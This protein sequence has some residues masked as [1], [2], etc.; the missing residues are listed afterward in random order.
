MEFGILTEREFSHPIKQ[1]S[2]TSFCLVVFALRKRGKVL[3]LDLKLGL[4]LMTTCTFWILWSSDS[5][6]Q[7]CTE[8]T[9]TLGMKTIQISSNIN[10]INSNIIASVFL[11][12]DMYITLCFNFCVKEFNSDQHA[13]KQYLTFDAFWK[14]L[15]PGKMLRPLGTS[16]RNRS[17]VIALRSGIRYRW[18]C[19]CCCLRRFNSV[20]FWH[21]LA[22]LRDLLCDLFCM[23]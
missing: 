10:L 16:P 2:H 22:Y 12:C 17:S 13:T 15:C 9:W 11:L 21:C 5:R 8:F 1:T 23:E 20:W 6:L 14:I 19:C 18:F 4:A 7:K 3:N